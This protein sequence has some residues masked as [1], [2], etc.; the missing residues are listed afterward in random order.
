MLAGDAQKT[1]R[2]AY[3]F[4]PLGAG[5][6]LLRPFH[7]FGI[8]YQTLV[9]LQHL[10][11]I[12]YS[13]LLIGDMNQ[14]K[15]S[16]RRPLP[17]REREICA[18]LKQAR[19]IIGLSQEEAAFQLGITRERLASYEDGRVAIRFELALKFCRQFIFSEEWLALGSLEIVKRM[20][21]FEKK[22]VKE[23]CLNPLHTRLCMSLATEPAYHQI[24]AGTLFSK[25]WDERL[26]HDYPVLRLQ[27]GL[28][29]Y[30]MLRGDDP[31]IARHF[32][33]VVCDY[34]RYGMDERQAARFI[35]SVVMDAGKTRQR[36]EAG[37]L[38]GDE[39][40]IVIDRAKRRGQLSA[41]VV[42]ALST[43]EQFIKAET[44]AALEMINKDGE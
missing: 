17:K 28:P 2:A 41:E 43:L 21:Q 14:Q 37:Q 3:A 23:Y 26:K 38:T 42:K 8:Q 1:R 22:S 20:A 5:C 44:P 15:L 31:K 24:K 6:F 27:Y 35:K 29:R 18:R 34:Y 32:L 10:L 33:N 16:G 30:K 36:I 39:R 9:T 25:A 7:I 19:A 11:T 4:D 13:S 12:I 40:E